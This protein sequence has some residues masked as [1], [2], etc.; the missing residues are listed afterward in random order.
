LDRALPARPR[1]FELVGMHDAHGLTVASRVL[2]ER[3]TGVVDPAL[4]EVIDRAVR[5]RRPDELG[6]GLGDRSKADVELGAKTLPCGD[7]SLLHREMGPFDQSGVR[8]FFAK[9]KQ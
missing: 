3:D 7:A 9:S 6:H 5:R 2:V 8:T 1:F 4:V